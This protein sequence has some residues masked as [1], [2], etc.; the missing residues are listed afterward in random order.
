V[1]GETSTAGAAHCSTAA[2]AAGS[3]STAMC[4]PVE[5]SAA[6]QAIADAEPT[7]TTADDPSASEAAGAAM[8][9]ARPASA[10]ACNS[11]EL[12]AVDAL[13]QLMVEDDGGG[14]QRADVDGPRAAPPP[15]G[16]P[17]SAPPS[18]P[19]TLSLDDVIE[20][21]SGGEPEPAQPGMS[22]EQDD[23][24][25]ELA[26]ASALVEWFDAGAEASTPAPRRA[27]TPPP[28][29]PNRGEPPV[30]YPRREPLGS[31][32]RLGNGTAGGRMTREAAANG[33]IRYTCVADTNTRSPTEPSAATQTQPTPDTERRHATSLGRQISN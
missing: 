31:H 29:T 25:P 6:G 32:M 2:S 28:P 15:A 33:S 22:S 1:T 8:G 10:I 27:P 26:N 21:Y 12:G 19:E 4:A 11:T 3:S 18:P 13:L 30:L 16:P 7:C 17:P 5:G 20:L 9:E 24:P 23:E 14:E